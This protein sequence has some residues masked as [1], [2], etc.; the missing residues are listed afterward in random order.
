[1]AVA[2]PWILPKDVKDYTEQKDVKERSDA[3]LEFD[4]TRA[5]QR[6]IKITNNRFDSE[7]YQELPK[8]V[9]MA[10]I[11]IAE[12]YA[13]NTIE[14]TRRQIKS[15]TF[16]DYSYTA[17]SATIDLD[18]LNLEELLSDYVVEAGIGRVVMKM[19]SL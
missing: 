9:K 19:R 2:R 15:E 14:G 11:L 3:K 13:K 17:E 7:E 6:V 16:D 8:P 18:N 10:T 4:I 12:A 1:M 5:E